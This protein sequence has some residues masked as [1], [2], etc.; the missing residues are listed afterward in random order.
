MIKINKENILGLILAGGQSK[1]MG[2]INKSLAIINNKSLLEI[3]LSLVKK[4]LNT[5]IINS[6]V[7]LNIAN[8]YNLPIIKDS[9]SGFF[10]P[11]AGILAAMEYANK[12]KIKWLLTVPCDAPFFPKDLTKKLLSHAIKKK[13]DIVIAKSGGRNHPVFGIWST[14]LTKSLKTALK[15]KQ[16]RKMDVW[17]EEHNFSVVNFVYDKIDPF[18]N[19]NDQ[20]DLKRA[21]K[22]YKNVKSIK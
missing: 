18:F 1:R 19:I 5:V 7:R 20:K 8:K 12:K 16:I 4:Q 6:N 13:K 10:G 22:I 17:I 21:N 15:K 14:S 3:T 11:L 2:N 9:L